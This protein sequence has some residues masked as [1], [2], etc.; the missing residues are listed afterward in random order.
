MEIITDRLCLREVT[1][2]DYDFIYGLDTNEFIQRF[3]S[4]TMPARE[5][6][7]KKFV[8]I[9]DDINKTP[10]TRYTLII[11]TLPDYKPVGRVIIWE[12]DPVLREWEMGWDVH[13]DYIGSGYAPEAARALMEYA[14]KELGVHRVQALCN[15]TNINSERV[16]IKSGMIKEG[17]CR[18]VRLL[19][20]RW[21]GSHI[22]ALL[23][24][25]FFS[26]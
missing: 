26:K 24:S 22:Y 9:L 10:R 3:E 16:M 13:P 8:K 18:G 17:T 5:D 4:D 11:T 1:N 20:N 21:Y 12:I 6:I 19:N 15:D 25:D 23:D 2:K 14:F 7:D